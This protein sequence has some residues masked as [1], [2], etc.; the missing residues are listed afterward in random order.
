MN[1]KRFKA[2]E[3]LSRMDNCDGEIK[4]LYTRRDDIVNSMSGIGKY[5]DKAVKGGSDPNPTEAKL[6]EY[7]TIC[8]RIEKL[9]GEMSTENTRTLAV[10]NQVK[11]SKL[12]GMMIGRYINHLSWEKVGK[13]FYYAKSSSYTY[14]NKCLDAVFPFIPTDEF[15]QEDDRFRSLNVCTYTD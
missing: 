6:I 12:R 11:S 15:I 9:E 4:M 7:S 10:I 13:M 1:D 3:W 5:D 8:A 14:Q 2:N